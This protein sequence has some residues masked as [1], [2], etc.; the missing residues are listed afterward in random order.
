[1]QTVA[2]LDFETTGLS[3]NLG[4]RATEIAVILLRDGQVVDR[5]QSLMNAGRRI[6]SDVVALT[7]I[8][9]E[10][11][12]S[13]PPASKVMKEAAAFVGKHAV[14]AHNAGFDK[15]FWQAE[16][17]LLGMTAEHAFACTMLVA[18]RIY[19]DALSHR[20]SSLADM[21]RLPKSGRAH[22]AMVDA[23]MAS[24]LWCRLQ[25]DIARTYGLDRIDHALMARVQAT[26]KAKVPMYLRSLAGA[27]A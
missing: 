26:A 20:L 15:R 25:Q 22:R 21:L 7:G 12:A 10:M 18:R 23:E 11:I 2:V 4:D 19:P 9:N 13:A 14:V 3:P 1:M 17:G 27:H 24:H 5:F 6:P 8:T 16:L